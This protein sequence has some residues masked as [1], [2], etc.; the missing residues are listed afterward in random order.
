MASQVT[1]SQPGTTI[2]VPKPITF[3]KGPGFFTGLK[4]VWKYMTLASIG[5]GIVAWFFGA[6]KAL[7]VLDIA[8]KA[9][10]PT[11]LVVSWIFVLYLTAGLTGIFLVLHYKQPF[12]MAWPIPGAVFIGAALGHMPFPE[13]VGAFVLTG[14]L[15]II[16]GYSG[17]V[18]RVMNLIPVP[19]MMGMVA[20]VFVPFGIN[21]IMPAVSIPWI[22]V[23]TFGIFVIFNLM[24]GVS[25]K[26]P[27]T[28][29]ALIGGTIFVTLVG[30]SHWSGMTF[31]W[32]SLVVPGMKFTL[33]GFLELTIPMTL[34]IVGV[35]NTQAFG[36]LMVEDYQ[37]PVASITTVGGISTLVNSIFG[38][39]PGSVAGPTTAILVDP[40][41]G[42]KEGRYA[43]AL[44]NA[45]LWVVFAFCA[46]EVVAITRVVPM[47]FIVMMAGLAMLGVLVSSFSVAFGSKHRIGALFAFVIALSNIVVLKIGAPFWALLFGVV[48][49]RLFEPADFSREKTKGAPAAVTFR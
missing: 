18:T 46:P 49:S 7:I 31:S 43:A 22:W 27:A 35:N 34:T 25:A 6:T 4:D 15:V 30:Q 48:I 45:V 40:A 47:A 44:V 8:A 33:P 41:C 5:S 26:F 2:P 38:G 28:L 19:I 36:V 1:T 3:E 21:I 17:L 9:K 10:L 42:P 16:L 12:G 37:P 39:S 20:G 13:I 11:N 14:V 32:P 29:A 23:V 24:R